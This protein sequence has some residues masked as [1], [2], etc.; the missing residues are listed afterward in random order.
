[1]GS[2][3]VATLKRL[4]AVSSNRCAFPKC[5]SPLVHGEKVTGRVA[6]IRARSAG[7]P[8]YD[9]SL[10][11]EELHGF[12][13]LLLLCSAH[14]DVIDADELAYT[15]ARLLEMKRAHESAKAPVSE[16]SDAQA[17]SLIHNEI[18]GSPQAT[19]VSSVNQS[20]G[21]TA[22]SVTVNQAPEPEIH[23]E[24]VFVNKP[25]PSGYHTRVALKLVSPYPPGNLAVQVT[26][27]SIVSAQ[28]NPQRSGAVIK[29]HSGVRGNMAFD[30]LQQPYGIIHLD[31]LMRQP[32]VP[33]ITFGIE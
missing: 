9:S 13:N 23:Y 25:T 4:F 11:A 18:S 5:A 8:R 29:G 10:S 31:I 22:A 7:G 30:N 2:P 33:D 15:V 14:H 26:S 16:L 32:D 1:M 12:D 6:H 17:G 28:L 27:P 24:E 21:I 3:T 19:I 20:G